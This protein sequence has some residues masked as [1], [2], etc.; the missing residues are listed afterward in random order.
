M[1]GFSMS[2]VRNGKISI[3]RDHTRVTGG[4][5]VY[6][7]PATGIS[8]L[9]VDPVKLLQENALEV[10]CSHGYP[11]LFSMKAGDFPFELNIPDDEIIHVESWDQD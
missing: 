5:V 7:F 1:L 9:P 11:I 10:Y 3:I 2:V 8:L 4:E 6:S